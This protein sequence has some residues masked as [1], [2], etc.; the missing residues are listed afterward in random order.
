VVGDAYHEE[1]W[2]CTQVTEYLGVTLNNLRQ[3]QHRGRIKWKKRQGRNVYY[4]AAEVRAYGE[5]RAR[6]KQ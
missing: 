5:M 4:I 1:W 2:S 6:G 3:L